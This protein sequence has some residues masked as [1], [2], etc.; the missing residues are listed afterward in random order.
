MLLTFTTLLFFLLIAVACLA[1]GIFAKS[2]YPY[3]LSMVIFLF[4]GLMII[5]LGISEQTGQS[6]QEVVSGNQTSSTVNYTY[7]Q[8]T[9]GWTTGFGLLFILIAGGLML[10]F[11]Y[12]REDKK[13]KEADSLEVLD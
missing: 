3:M 13:Q 8:T 2:Q 9:S 4:M 10:N 5:Q 12:E 11:Y 1:I 7:A 6:V